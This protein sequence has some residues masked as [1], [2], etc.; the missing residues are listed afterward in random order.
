MGERTVRDWLA[1]GSYPE[2]K[3][4]RRRPSLVDRYEREVLK[5][6]EQGNHN[7]ASLYRELRAQG[8]RGSQKA[9]YRYLARLRAPRQRSLMLEKEQVPAGPL[10]RLSAGRITRL[11]LRKSV[12]LSQEEQEELF[13]IRQA[14]P[15]I[16]AAYQLVQT[17]LQ[18][19]R[20]RTG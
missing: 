13:Q 2:P 16:E 7:G 5:R 1:H 9:L 20:E 11:F 18:M 6:W 3:R 4:R 12:D 10:E 17:F 15:E 14:S 8:Y 19:L